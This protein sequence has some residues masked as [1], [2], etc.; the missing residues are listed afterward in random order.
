MSC[1]KIFVVAPANRACHIGRLVLCAGLVRTKLGAGCGAYW[2]RLAFRPPGGLLEKR[3]QNTRRSRAAAPAGLEPP[4]RFGLGLGSDWSGPT[5]KVEIDH[6]RPAQ[7]FV[8]TSPAHNQS[9]IGRV[10]YKNWRLLLCL[11]E[12]RALYFRHG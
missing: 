1:R 9:H 6:T 4:T 10:F 3:N 12:Q 5:C 7:S 8:P 2:S 11:H